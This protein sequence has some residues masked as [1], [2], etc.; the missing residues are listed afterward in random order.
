[1]TLNKKREGDEIQNREE[2]W[3]TLAELDVQSVKDWRTHMAHI[4]LR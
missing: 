1:M 4:W 3:M 2:K